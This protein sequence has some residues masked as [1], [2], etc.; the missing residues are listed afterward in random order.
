MSAP[1]LNPKTKFTQVQDSDS[2]AAR[3]RSRYN[4]DKKMYTV[5]DNLKMSKKLSPNVGRWTTV[6][7]LMRTPNNCQ[8]NW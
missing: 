4:V 2:I 6:F 5:S 1:E 8:K 3:T 7:R